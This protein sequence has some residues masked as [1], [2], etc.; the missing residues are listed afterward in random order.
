GSR[1]LGVLLAIIAMKSQHPIAWILL[2]AV[3][4]FDGVTGL[5][6]VFLKRFFK[7]SILKNIRTPLHDEVRKNRGWSDTQVVV[8]FA[9]IQ[10]L[11]A[12]LWYITTL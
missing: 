8:R 11:C 1:P 12:V 3:F 5:V 4:L 6:K 7:I 2:C 9:I 10:A